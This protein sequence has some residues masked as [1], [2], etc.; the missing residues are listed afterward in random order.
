MRKYTPKNDVQKK[1]YFSDR[2]YVTPETPKKDP[3]EDPIYAAD[4]EALKSKFEI[5]NSYIEIDELVVYINNEDNVN[6]LTFLKQELEYEM[7]MELSAIDYIAQKGGFEIFYEMLSLSKKRRMRVKT[8]IRQKQ[9]IES[10]YSVFKMANWAEREMYDMYGVKV[11]NHPNMKRILMPD[12]W[13][14]HPLRKTYPLHGDEAAQWYEVD[15]IF[16]KEAREEIGPEIRD[17]AN[18]DRYDT[19]RFARLGHEVPYGVDITDGKEPEHTP[20][21]YQEEGGVVIIKKLHEDTSVTLEER[22]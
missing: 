19:Q 14:D 15:K 11:T 6:V 3:S 8:F 4:I 16:G 7:L 2:F 21:G 12:D 22:R 18:V 5:V 10:V 9:P 20:L 17:G 13:Y 1:S